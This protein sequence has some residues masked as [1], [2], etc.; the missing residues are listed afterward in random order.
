MSRLT[1]ILLFVV[2]AGLGYLALRQAERERE[3][4]LDVMEALYPD[5]EPER[6]V[7]LRVEDIEGSR[8]FRFE[9]GGGPRWFLVDPIRWPADDE[10]VGELLE[11]V[12]RSRAER[13]PDELV[14]QAEA[15]LDPPRG[16][17]ETLERLE[18]GTERRVRVEIG[19][20]DLDGIRV[21][22]RRDGE[23]LRTL[24]KVETP[25]DFSL[26][27]YRE[28]RLFAI[29]GGVAE[30]ERIGGWV[31][32]DGG[33]LVPLDLAVSARSGRWRITKPIEAPA[34]PGL[35]AAWLAY[36]GQV[37]AL[38]FASDRP[39]PDLSKYGL[40]RPRMTIRIENAGGAES[41][42]NFGQLDASVY[43]QRGRFPNIFQVSDQELQYLTERPSNFF[44]VAIL[45][46]DRPQTQRLWLVRPDRSLRFSASIADRGEWELAVVDTATGEVL[47]ERRPDRQRVDDMLAALEAGEVRHYLPPGSVEEYFPADEDGIVE[48]FVETG[49]DPRLGGRFASSE[50]LVGG[51]AYRPFHRDGDSVATAVDPA[52]GDLFLGPLESYLDRYLW[53]LSNSAQRRLEV[54]RPGGEGRAWRRAEEFDWRADGPDVEAAEPARE[55]DPVLDHLLF[56]RAERHLVEAERAPL[57]DVVEVEFTDRL[58]GASVARIGRVAGGDEVRIEVGDLQS[59]AV[60]PE[61]HADLVALLD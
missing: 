23:V 46:F 41:V 31:E 10:R 52:V 15:T 5:V 33:D 35:M 25:I 8:T 34:D 20:V 21:F 24:R 54:R 4:P 44:D 9:N 40:E 14:A 59:I 57:E 48:V 36:L 43:A 18:D 51:D 61:L 27:E 56:L 53:S 60:R 30:V 12:F 32:E 58:D 16:F 38:M 47:E 50:V 17:L 1:P 55:L 3:N 2:V 26:R 11:V 49:T 42:V 7:G 37:E 45:R 29:G 39:D 19:G 13:V 28:K 22:V 6:L